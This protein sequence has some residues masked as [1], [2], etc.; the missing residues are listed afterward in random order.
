[1]EKTKMEGYINDCDVHQW[2]YNNLPFE[3]KSRGTQVY[4]YMLKW[5]VGKNTSKF[6]LCPTP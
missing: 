3:V 1:M 5:S 6:D 2:A 4:K